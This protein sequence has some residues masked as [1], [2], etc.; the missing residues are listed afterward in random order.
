L[1]AN[2]AK[3]FTMCGSTVTATIP[4]DTLTLHLAEDAWNGDATFT[5]S[6]DGKTIITAQA[7]TAS[8]SA[9]AAAPLPT[10]SPSMSGKVHQPQ[11]VAVRILSTSAIFS[12]NVSGP[13]ETAPGVVVPCDVASPEPDESVY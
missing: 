12:T 6:I 9:R 13:S 8:D 5:L 4:T 1:A 2:E 3:D 7:V 10:S 11:F